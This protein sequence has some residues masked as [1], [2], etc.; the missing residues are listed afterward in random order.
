MKGFGLNNILP[1]VLLLGS[2]CLQAEE[3]YEVEWS[4]HGTGTTGNALTVDKN[5]D[6]VMTGLKY[7][8]E[9]TMFPHNELYI[10]KYTPDGV[11][12]WTR[13]S[14]IA[15]NNEGHSVA[16]DSGN[17]IIIAGTI[18][19]NASE[20]A[21]GKDVF[22]RKYTPYGD[23]LWNLRFGTA[24]DDV[25]YSIT[26]DGSDNLFV[27]GTTDNAFTGQTT[28]NGGIDTFI[29]KITPEGTQSWLK[30]FGT[31]G[32]DE[33]RSIAIDTNGNLFVTG[34]TSGN[35]PGQTDGDGA[36]LFIAK[37]SAAGDPSWIQQ[38]DIS[39]NDVGEGIAVDSGN[40]LVVTGTTNIT[41]YGDEDA[42]VAKFHNDGGLQWSSHFESSSTE[43][44]GKSVTIDKDDHIVITGHQEGTSCV[45]DGFSE[46]ECTDYAKAYVTKYN[47]DGI[48][49]WERT[50]N[51][52][53][54]SSYDYGYSIAADSSGDLFVAGH[55]EFTFLGGLTTAFIAKLSPNI[56]PGADA[57][58]DSSAPI[59]TSAALNGG[60][61]SD[62]DEDY[63]LTFA[64]EFVSV[65]EGSTA[66]LAAADTVSPSFTPDYPGDYIV[67]LVVTDAKGKASAPDSVTV[68]TYNTP[69]LADAG[70]DQAIDTVGSLVALD[71]T[72]SYDDNGDA[73]T[74]N[75]TIDQ[76][77]A[78]SSAM[79]DDPASMTP[80]FSADVN[81]E[82][83]ITL[84]VTDTWG[85]AA[86]DEVVVSFDNVV[87]VAD[88]GDNQAGVIGDA[89]TLDGSGSNDANGDPLTYSWSLST[90][91]EGS[92][93]AIADPASAVTGFIPDV[94]GTYVAALVVNDG[95]VDSVPE[96]AEIV[97]VSVKDA[98]TGT[99]IE[100]IDTI[101]A[102]P[103]ES[104]SNLNVGNALTNKL[105]AVLSMIAKGQYEQALS[106]LQSDIL[107]KTDGCILNGAPDAQDWIQE[108]AMQELVYNYVMETIAGL[109][110]LI[111]EQ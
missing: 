48:L 63:P 20:G 88:A 55:T 45:T 32:N 101:N 24:G 5:G 110:T 77:P 57:G 66:V 59:G 49:L 109:E 71:G 1:A 14:D 2:V 25:G 37:Y 52:G 30:Q 103:E 13:Q 86:G 51:T 54:A 99:V 34:T 56:A 29:A 17:G 41:T 79:L 69:P 74:Y 78:N 38:Y 42:F 98:T 93:A 36:D 26:V 44:A 6:L 15:I 89:V 106:K 82:Y 8:T 50:F 40:N 76:K 58:A 108:C 53:D 111:A 11:L 28:S 68:N 67:Q 64:W 19:S 43:E 102:L 62:P 16:I 80:S 100:T 9:N 96:S 95:I 10:A 46:P 107:P 12:Q 65:P 31:A 104:F 91:P 22:I 84:T 97:V 81:G 94:E 72:G 47:S 61:S 73:L 105:N 23:L 92:L 70:S 27:T 83:H 33:G 85:A 18:A 60:A 75:W 7:V 87:P 4:H 21:G 90:K 35:F 3:A 39:S